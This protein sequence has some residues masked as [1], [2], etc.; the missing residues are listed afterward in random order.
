[1]KMVTSILILCVLA[2]PAFAVIK[3]NGKPSTI[4]QDTPQKIQHE[5]EG[6]KVYSPVKGSEEASPSIQTN[7]IRSDN[8]QAVVVVSQHISSQSTTSEAP[9]SNST[10]LHTNHGSAI[11]VMLGLCAVVFMLIRRSVK[12]SEKR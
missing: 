6:Q 8:P 9:R 10:N 1:M 7:N 11:A 3:L 2:T 5:M 12:S 4:E